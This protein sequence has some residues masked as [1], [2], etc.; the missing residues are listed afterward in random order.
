M[1]LIKFCSERQLSI[2]G[3]VPPPISG[4]LP[5]QGSPVLLPAT[6]GV[7]QV[8]VTG[9]PGA[10]VPQPMPQVSSAPFTGAVPPVLQSN[11]YAAPALSTGSVS[12]GP[13]NPIKFPDSG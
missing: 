4:S 3:I 7:P 8:G 12:T 6:S 5:P 2:P 13:I 10:V 1:N 9:I 11:M